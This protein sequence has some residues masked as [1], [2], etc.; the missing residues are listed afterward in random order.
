MQRPKT[1]VAYHSVTGHTRALADDI[2]AE[3]GATIH[4]IDCPPLDTGFAPNIKRACS[5]DTQSRPRITVEGE[6]TIEDFDS[7]VIGGPVWVGR[8][9]TPL[10]S[11]LRQA[12]GRLPA[13]VAIFLS[14]SSSEP[15]SAAQP[16]IAMLPQKPVAM[17][18]IG[19]RDR[20]NG[21]QVAMMQ[22]FVA[23]LV[24]ASSRS[25]HGQ[26]PD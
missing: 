8:A 11:Y 5:S 21:R 23:E 9:A 1:L 10:A 6:G 22:D 19:N 25:I 7:L 13:N 17:V 3:L 4:R 14:S 26:R 15:H 18:S 2:A 16:L 20:T 24:N 12:A